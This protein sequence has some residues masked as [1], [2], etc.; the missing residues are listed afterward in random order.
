MEGPHGFDNSKS[1]WKDAGWREVREL[2]RMLEDLKELTTLV[3]SLGRSSGKGKLRRA[4]Q[5]VNLS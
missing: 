5:E 2:R 1:V 3:R 4:P